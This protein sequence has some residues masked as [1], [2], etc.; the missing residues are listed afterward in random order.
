[1]GLFRK[2]ASVLLIFFIPIMIFCFANNIVLRMPDAYQFSFKST[3]ILREN[4]IDVSEDN[5]GK[6]ISSYMLYR[7]EEFQLREDQELEDIEGEFIFT[8]N[9][10]IAAESIRTVLNVLL[11]VGVIFLIYN[12]ITYILFIKNGFKAILRNHFRISLIVLGI[13]MI[14]PI[15]AYNIPVISD[16]IN[17]FVY[18]IT[19][20]EADMIPI[21]LGRNFVKAYIFSL[22]VVMIV[23]VG[24]FAYIT[25][26]KTKPRRMFW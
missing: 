23:L 3:E 17:N 6:F 4:G 12:V 11:A 18:G 15:V 26:I 14:L 9:D 22:E 2:I 5:M 20:N 21:I 10:Q 25:W 13:L 24:F 8:R 1:M 16:I 7:Q 19:F